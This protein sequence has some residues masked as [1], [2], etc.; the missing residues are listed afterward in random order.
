[1][2]SYSP[3]SNNSD[4]QSDQTD[5]DD[6]YGDIE[7]QRMASDTEIQRMDSKIKCKLHADNRQLKYFCEDH[8]V[9][10]CEHCSQHDHR[11]CENIVD[12]AK[13]SKG[14][15][16]H[17]EYK[18]KTARLQNLKADIEKLQKTRQ[19][20]KSRLDQEKRDIEQKM[21]E[22]V[23]KIQEKLVTLMQKG[24]HDLEYKYRA[25]E[26]DINSDLNVLEK[27]LAEVNQSITGLQ[28]DEKDAFINMKTSENIVKDAKKTIKNVD[29]HARKET[30]QFTVNPVI[31]DALQQPNIGTLI[32]QNKSLPPKPRLFHEVCEYKI[33]RQEQHNVN[34]NKDKKACHI[35]DCCLLHDGTMILT[36]IPHNSLVHIDQTFTLKTFCKLSGAPWGVCT[37]GTNGLAVT[38]ID[39]K[40]IQLVSTGRSLTLKNSFS[41]GQEPCRGIFFKDGNLFVCCGGGS[42]Y[43][44]SIREGP[45][46]IKQYNLQGILLQTFEKDQSGKQI[47]R[48]PRDIIFNTENERFYITDEENGII[49]LNRSG[50][51]VSTIT[52]NSL[53]AARGIAFDSR[54]QMFVGCMRSSQIFL[55]EEN[56][57]LINTLV[58]SSMGISSV[59]SL[60]FKADSHKLIVTGHSNEIQILD[61]TRQ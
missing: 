28:Q 5:L 35:L 2:A 36:D 24:K 47:F 12:L 34:I 52:N 41:V 43:L 22:T 32:F 7:M 33:T 55:F 3:I 15:K 51:R 37:T 46:Q 18:N 27:T 6:T 17:Q 10:I 44:L 4:K 11:K 58:T 56:G 21:Q 40:E 45:G 61:L 42:R 20:D 29:G 50:Q 23:K 59:R 48:R 14:V 13:I 8:D 38:L 57:T 30:L 49:I 53:T 19:D 1:M 31:A 25:F 16:Q 60:C 54:G 9:V 39:K 26:K